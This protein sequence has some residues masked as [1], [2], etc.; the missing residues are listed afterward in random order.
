MAASEIS[1]REDFLSVEKLI[2]KYRCDYGAPRTRCAFFVSV[3]N[4]CFCFYC[5]FY[6]FAKLCGVFGAVGSG[7]E[8][9][10]WIGTL[11]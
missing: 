4:W 10:E 11:G 8:V 5:C 6:C 7:L 3:E 9:L 1:E 2:V